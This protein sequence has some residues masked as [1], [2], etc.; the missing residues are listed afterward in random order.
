MR[1]I[2]VK[3]FLM[4]FGAVLLLA[5]PAR[6]E[7]AATAAFQKAG[8]VGAGFGG[9]NYAN[10]L[11]GKLYLAD[12]FAVQGSV[13]FVPGWG[14]GGLSLAVD[15]VI[16][17]PALHVQPEFGVNWNFGAGGSLFTNGLGLGAQGLAG[18]R[19]WLNQFPL[20]FVVE[21]R[22]TLWLTGDWDWVPGFSRLWISGGASARWFF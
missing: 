3:S 12:A 10:G 16:E 22:P 11:T 21:L 19:L 1:N 17:M 14:S 2:L 15:A 13:G 18:L 6:A 5:A 9:S 8:K 7:G 4:A 20:E